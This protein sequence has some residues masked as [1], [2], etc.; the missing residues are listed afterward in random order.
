[1][2]DFSE[3]SVALCVD[4]S[5]VYLY[6]GSTDP[7]HSGGW[8]WL[9]SEVFIKKGSVLETCTPYDTSALNCDGWCVCDNCPPVEEVDGYRLATNNGSKIDE[10]K[11]AVYYQGPV[12]MAFYYTSSGEYSVEPWGTIY[13]YYPCSGSTNHIVSIIGWDDAVPHPNSSHGG[14]GAWIVKN[15]WGTGWGN[16]GFF[17]LAYH[18][19]C[20]MEIAYLEYRD[21]NPAEELLYWD[22]AGLVYNVG[23]GDNNAGM[24]SVFTATQSGNLTHVDFWT[25]S[26]NAQYE[27]YVWDDYFGSELANQTGN[28]QEF[29]YY[30]IPLNKSIPIDAGQQFTVG[31]KMTTPGYNYP[32]PVE[33]EISGQVDP[34]IYSLV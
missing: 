7:C 34:L 13:D 3:Q 1:V 16:N 22:E 17:Y 29:G 31:V 9:A 26:N 15:S 32:I 33:G 12:T 30:S 14:T 6:A 21:D 27:I 18:S 24:A 4:P 28:C 2:Y 19:S 23:Y 5:W 8:S 11:N 20:V 10:I 25:T